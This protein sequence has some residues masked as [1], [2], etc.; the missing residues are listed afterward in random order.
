MKN[1]KCKAKYFSAAEKDSFA[2]F[3]VENRF[4][5]IFMGYCSNDYKSFSE[6]TL[7][8]ALS[9]NV[10][11]NVAD[12]IVIDKKDSIKD[13]LSK[14]ILHTENLLNTA[15]NK[16]GNPLYLAAKEFLAA[17]KKALERDRI[18]WSKES[19][20]DDSSKKNKD[21]GV[22]ESTELKLCE[23]FKYAPFFEAEILFYHTLLANKKYFSQDE[24]DEK[25]FEHFDFFASEKK[26]SVLN[27][28]ENFIKILDELIEKKEHNLDKKDFI[29]AMHYCLSANTS[30]LSQLNAKERFEYTVD[31][32]R[33]LHDDTEVLYEYINNRT[34]K[35]KQFDIICD[36]AGKE[37]FSDLYLA[38]YFLYNEIVKK[39]VFHLKPYPFF[40]SDA[41]KEDFGYMISEIQKAGRGIGVEKCNEYIHDGRIEIRTHQFWAE[42]LCFD[43]MPYS[44][45]KHF[46]KSNLT[47]IKGD[48]N[49]RRLVK[50]AN[51]NYTDKFKKRTKKAFPLT[52]IVAPRVLKSDVLIGISDASYQFAKSTDKL[53]AS[54]DQRFKGNGK[55]AV[56]QFRVPRYKH[57]KKLSRAVK[58]NA[59]GKNDSGNSNEKSSEKK[60]EEHHKKNDKSKINAWHI[61][62]CILFIVLFGSIIYLLWFSLFSPKDSSNENWN[63]ETYNNGNLNSENLNKEKQS[64]K[65]LTAE[66]TKRIDFTLLLGGYA[67]LL[68]GTLII[69][70]VMLKRKLKEL[71]AEQEEDTS[72]KIRDS[73]VEL[74]KPD[75]NDIRGDK[76]KLDA[77]L[78]RMVSFLLAVM[79]TPFWSL[80]WAFHSLKRYLESARLVRRKEI[81]G[82]I[83]VLFNAVIK[84]QIKDIV[85]QAMCD[86][87]N[88]DVKKF[89]SAFPDYSIKNDVLTIF[90]VRMFFEGK[91]RNEEAP[92]RAILALVKDMTDVEYSLET[93]RYLINNDAELY[94]KI[95]GISKY[96]GIFVRFIV[97]SL[98]NFELPHRTSDGKGSYKFFN[99]KNDFTESIMR[100][101]KN[102]SDD[103]Y[104]KKFDNAV[105]HIS[106]D[107][108]GLQ[109][110]ELERMP[111]TQ[112]VANL[113][114]IYIDDEKNTQNKIYFFTSDDYCYPLPE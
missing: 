77:D 56:I 5:K 78:S 28:K 97:Y 98:I 87:K 29:K 24:S 38:C 71:V 46:C 35:F 11:K 30:D 52:P 2:E 64:F 110:R 53:N 85:K 72:R 25:R 54:P 76:L 67:V 94:E 65:N 68:S 40:V 100:I 63:N 99:T 69:P 4:E 55:W 19:L 58:Q 90:A 114:R 3:T 20:D 41:T 31:D 113:R 37:L 9:L 18:I 14:K 92:L 6:N 86:A 81:Y 50:D 80:G 27:G 21:T 74:I 43:R 111:D 107:V 66:D 13:T 93:D 33:I 23:I 75:L 104:V 15:T 79:K 108:F 109:K 32:I 62:I 91:D 34:G 112:L 22:P 84:T 101:S 8:Q 44:L 42:P 73:V 83:D 103:K 88:L 106:R 48:L 12:G 95:D 61:L 26:N 49:Y 36:N 70:E 10:N 60:E 39:V 51:W 45:R 105:I 96:I 7:T 16:D 47:I 89:E 59:D 82:F 102:S 17:F 57:Y 1:E